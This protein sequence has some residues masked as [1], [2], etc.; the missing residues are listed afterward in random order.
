MAKN[1]LSIFGDYISES[2]EDGT[3]IRLSL[4]GYA[5]KE[6]DLKKVLVRKINIKNTPHLSFTYRYQTRDIVKNYLPPVAQE[7]ILDY[8]SSGFS[9]ATLFTSKN[10]IAYPA[11]KL[12]KATQK[13][14]ENL[15]HDRL[16]NRHVETIG[17]SYLHDLKITD[18]NGDVL[19]TAQ[20]KFRQIDKYIEILATHLKG[21]DPQK[22]I[23]VVDM[24]A[25]KG[26]LTFALYDYLTSTLNMNVTA[27]GV[28]YRKDLVDLCNKIA[29][30]AGFSKLSFKQGTIEGFDAKDVNV[31]IALH[32]C[33]TATDDAIA[34]GVEASADL[35]VVA[36]CCHKQIRKQMEKNAAHNLT[37]FIVRHGIFMERQAE[38]VTDS[39]R[40]LMLEY[41]GYDVK[42]F[43][44]ISGEHT[45]KNIMIV[46]SK[47]KKNEQIQKSILQKIN[48]IKTDFG[49]G[50]H[51]LEKIL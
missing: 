33:D 36:P 12:S 24:G 7:K 26:Y 3:F 18:K 2:L 28:E 30:N 48:K 35:I 21:F 23:N 49:I 46:A 14:D 31:L 16:K 38:M 29:T 17:K 10:D 25:G 44:F 4:G 11:L 19:K 45:A 51:A 15:S 5:G 42:V 22:N 9:T 27:T 8:L 43:E 40:A 47:K 41:A 1:K 20:D 34:K 13:Q 37:D 6:K 39:L 50:F 32:A